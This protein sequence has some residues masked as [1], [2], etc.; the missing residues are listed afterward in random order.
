LSGIEVTGVALSVVYRVA[1]I[2]IPHRTKHNVSTT[3]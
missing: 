2:K 1:Q 3:V